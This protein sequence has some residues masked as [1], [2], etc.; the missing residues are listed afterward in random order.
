MATDKATHTVEKKTPA[1]VQRVFRV[2]QIALTKDSIMRARTR[3]RHV[4]P[5]HKGSIFAL[6]SMYAENFTVELH[7]ILT[8][9]EGGMRHM[10]ETA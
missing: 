5:L 8:I 7:L 4:S 3:R 1:G 10:L 6:V 9:S 2:I